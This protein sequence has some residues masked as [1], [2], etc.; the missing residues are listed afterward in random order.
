MNIPMNTPNLTVE[1]QAS[2]PLETSEHQG[3]GRT[4]NHASHQKNRLPF[5]TILNHSG[6][7]LS[8]TPVGTSKPSTPC[9]TGQSKS[10]SAFV[11][12]PSSVKIDPLIAEV[13]RGDPIA[14]SDALNKMYYTMLLDQHKFEAY[15]S[16]NENGYH[17]IST[18]LNSCNSKVDKLGSDSQLIQSEIA[19]IMGNKADRSQLKSLQSQ[20]EELR[21]ENLSLRS[22]VENLESEHAITTHDLEHRISNNL[23]LKE[24]VN[25]MVI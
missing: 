20:I 12:D 18:K 7:L 15:L 16:F 5:L 14:M 3:I 10:Y 21:S 11:F 2:T 8:P 13:H 19:S 6:S 4:P 1:V 9:Q 24:L 25:Q 17:S 23:I 22:L